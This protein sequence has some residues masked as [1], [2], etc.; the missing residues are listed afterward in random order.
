MIE[1]DHAR[2]DYEIATANAV[3]AGLGP[4]QQL[5]LWVGCQPVALEPVAEG[6]GLPSWQRHILPAGTPP[7]VH[8]YSAYPASGW[9]VR[10]QSIVAD[11][12]RRQALP[13]S[14]LSCFVPA[15]ISS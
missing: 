11:Q 15:C 12:A 3:S 7:G 6:F 2:Y 5:R 4:Y 1:D 14:V 8:I 9:L 13:A 10:R